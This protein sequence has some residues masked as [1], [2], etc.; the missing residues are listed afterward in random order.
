MTDADSPSALRKP[1][2]GLFASRPAVPAVIFLIL[3]I[4]LG[5]DL[6]ARPWVY[7]G[8]CASATVMAAISRRF[9]L[10]SAAL[11]ALGLVSIGMVV[12]QC[13]Y[14]QYAGNDIGAFSSSQPQLAQVEF[15]IDGPPRLSSSSSGGR[16]SPPKQMLAGTVE[17]ILT[18]DGWTSASGSFLVQITHPDAMLADGQEVRVLGMLQRPAHATNPGE[19]DWADYYRDQRVLTSIKVSRPGNIQ[20]LSDRGTGPL[21][22]LREWARDLLAMGFTDKRAGDHAM[23]RALVLGDSDPMMRESQTQLQKIGVAYLLSISGMH[24]AVVAACVY[25]LCRLLMRSPRF[26]CWTCLAV[27]ILYGVVALPGESGLRAVLLCGAVVLGILFRR[28]IDKLQLLAIVAGML[29]LLNP[30]DLFGAGFELGFVCITGLILL[31]GPLLRWMWRRERRRDGLVSKRGFFRQAWFGL[32]AWVA[33]SLVAWIISMPL[34]AYHFGQL[35]LWAIPCGVVL[36]PVVTIALVGGCAKILLTLL[37]PSLAGWWA[38]AAALPIVELRHLAASLVH[39]PAASVAA[40]R[41]SVLPIAIY[42][43]VLC[44]PLLRWPRAWVQRTSAGLAAAAVCCLLASLSLG[45]TLVPSA[46]SG[47]GVSITFLDIGAGQCAVLEAPGMAPVMMDAGS[48]TISDV[49]RTC[50]GPFLNERGD[51]TIGAVML[52]HSDFDHISAISTALP[53]FGVGVVYTSHYFAHFA[54]IDPPAQALLDQLNHAGKTPHLIGRGDHVQLSRDVS[55]DVLW[56]PADC[57]FN[58]NNTGLVVK[59]SYA[60]R[61]V[62]F[63]ADIQADAMRELLKSPGQ[64]K[65]DVL[66]AAHHG[67]SEKTTPAFVKAVSPLFII[68]SNGSPLTEKQQ[69][70]ERM[71]GKRTLYRTNDCGAITLHIARDGTLSVDTFIPQKL[72]ASTTARN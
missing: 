69:L 32:R 58:C 28:D 59:L 26:A 22:W 14:L 43:G 33:I 42:Y 40:T 60:G 49:T 7:L 51:R 45:F 54:S 13:G 6:P 39:L 57:A 30:M 66:V 65:A 72:A 19:F 17:K 9:V 20:M 48:S 61:T 62:L 34:V 12:G 36:F 27:V 5:F 64:L 23:L 31:G 8:V 11:I 71:I 38:A 67:S 47:D 24:I 2:P 55:V 46:R 68:S 70:F 10:V 1:G 56:P 41:P 35:S 44:L 50:L 25:G 18:R 16:K 52:S 21:G 4:C 3:G 37:W 53:M 29:L 63:P 15:R